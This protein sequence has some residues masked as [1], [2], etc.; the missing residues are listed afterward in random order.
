[1][2]PTRPSDGSY[3]RRRRIIDIMI[4]RRLWNFRSIAYSTMQYA[5]FLVMRDIRGKPLGDLIEILR[6]RLA[7][8]EETFFERMSVSG[9]HQHESLA[10]PQ[11]LARMT[12]YVE[13]QSGLASRYAEYVAEAARSGYEVEHIWADK[14]RAA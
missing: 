13:T 1:M 6:Q 5:M 12:D 7:D 14:H 8:D 3:G 4:A 9:L 10:D 11:L 2:T